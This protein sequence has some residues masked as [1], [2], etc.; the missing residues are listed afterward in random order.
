MRGN[1]KMKKIKKLPNYRRWTKQFKF[2]LPDGRIVDVWQSLRS[3]GIGRRQRMFIRI[4]GEWYELNEDE[5][6]EVF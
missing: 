3:Y 6:I 4:N 2:K 1:M 5:K